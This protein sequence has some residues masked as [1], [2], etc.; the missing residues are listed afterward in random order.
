M[1]EATRK[2]DGGKMV[3]TRVNGGEVTITGDFF[4]HPEEAITDLERVVER[5]LDS[6]RQGL[7]E[8]V[9]EFLKES[10]V[11]LHG[12]SPHDIAVTVVEAR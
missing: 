12:A 6:T 9:K 11:E 10:G 7:E 2:I 3:R 8:A 5:N 4:M 1:A